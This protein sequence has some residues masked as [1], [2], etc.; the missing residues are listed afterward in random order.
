MYS[1]FRLEQ[2]YLDRFYD[3]DIDPE[4]LLDGE[5]SHDDV[6]EYLDYKEKEKRELIIFG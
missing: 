1:P 2:E 3:I 4:P 6:M 5:Y